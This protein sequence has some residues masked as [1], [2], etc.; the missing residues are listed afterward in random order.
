MK[1]K[2]VENSRVQNQSGAIKSG[3]CRGALEEGVN[4][5]ISLLIDEEEL[6]SVHLSS[7]RT[8]DTESVISRPGT[9]DK[10]FL[11]NLE[12][13]KRERGIHISSCFI[14]SLLAKR[15]TMGEGRPASLRAGQEHVWEDGGQTRQW[16][17]PGIISETVARGCGSATH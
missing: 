4:A 16:K 9:R 13:K 14:K 6:I 17:E 11:L 8:P 12:E 7:V 1:R 2:R 15:A 10:G 3:G 5:D